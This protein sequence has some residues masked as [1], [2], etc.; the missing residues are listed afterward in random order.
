MSP[1]TALARKLTLERIETAQS[2]LYMAAQVSAD[3]QGW[4]DLWQE[5]GDHADRTKE[6]WH[7]INNA[8]LPAGHDYEPK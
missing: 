4:A 8:P 5:I 7:K 6:L 3:I 2:F 1:T